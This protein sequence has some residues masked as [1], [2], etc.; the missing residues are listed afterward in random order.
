MSKAL[1]NN[2]SKNAMHGFTLLKRPGTRQSLRRLAGL[3]LLVC[4]LPSLAL[5]LEDV[6]AYSEELIAMFKKD[7]DARKNFDRDDPRSIDNLIETDKNNLARFKEIIKAIGWPSV[8]KVGAKASEGAFFIAQ[9][10]VTDWP[11]MEFALIHVEADYRAGK[12]TGNNY[13]LMYDRI[14]M[15]HGKPQKYGTQIVNNSD[16]CGVYQL[17]DAGKVDIYRQ[18]VGL[19]PDLKTYEAKMC[20]RR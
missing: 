2:W 20:G 8:D 5:A 12:S 14:N 10:A 9:H 18:D 15:L 19:T 1:S 11:L 17:E 16:G 4:A 6:S 3:A 7:Q 13:A